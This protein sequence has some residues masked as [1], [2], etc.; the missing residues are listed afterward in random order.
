MSDLKTAG[1]EL[2][3]TRSTSDRFNRRAFVGL[4]GAAAALAARPE[5]ALADDALGKPH[6]PL[7]AEDDPA[8]SVAHPVLTSARFTGPYQVN[9]YAVAPKANVVHAAG[10]V[11]VQ[12][13]WGVDAQLRDTARRLAKEGYRVIAPDLY[14]GLDAPSGDA[15][16]DIAAFRPIAGKLAD[17]S[18]DADLSA[19]ALWLRAQ[20]GRD[21]PL[22]VMGFCMGGAITLRQTVDKAHLYSAASVFYGKVRYGT[23]GDNGEITPIALSYAADIGP[24]LAG[25]YGARDTSIKPEDVRTLASHLAE[26]RK[27]HDIKVYDGAGHAFFDDTRDSYVAAAAGDAWARTLAWFKKYL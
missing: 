22:G 26:L 12:A 5:S 6:P 18:V 25:S 11:L 10:I 24:P 19:G 21:I 15:S 3:P 2:D 8:L 27:P 9:A 7:V 17:D 23:T 14:S 20:A 1:D 16:S 4:A 13:I